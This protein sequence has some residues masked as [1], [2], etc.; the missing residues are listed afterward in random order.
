MEKDVKIEEMKERP[1]GRKYLARTRSVLYSSDIQVI[2]D[3]YK[4]KNITQAEIAKKYRVTK[5]LV[6]RLLKEDK[7]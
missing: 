7:N 4:T 6:Q 2:L 5:T 1:A 3:E